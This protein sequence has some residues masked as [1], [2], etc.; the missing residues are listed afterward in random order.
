MFSTVISNFAKK[1]PKTKK[2][3]K[4]Q[5]QPKKERGRAKSWAIAME[6]I[7]LSII[8][9]FDCPF[10]WPLNCP[11]DWA[12]CSPFDCPVSLT[13]TI[14]AHSTLNIEIRKSRVEMISQCFLLMFYEICRRTIRHFAQI[15]IP[16]CYL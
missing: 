14:S 7:K 9:P 12:L 16:C 1:R 13:N 8:I 11:F 5:Q 10:D 3:Q 6:R 2:Q 15:K 4:Q